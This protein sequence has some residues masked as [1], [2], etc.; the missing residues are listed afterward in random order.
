MD[1]ATLYN[2]SPAQRGVVADDG[3]TYFC[4]PRGFTTI[5]ST[6]DK[7]DLPKGVTKKSQAAEPE[8]PASEPTPEQAQ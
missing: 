6:V 1:N 8:A 7:V 5:P 2:R 4:K 3:H